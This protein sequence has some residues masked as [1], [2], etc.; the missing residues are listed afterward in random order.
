MTSVADQQLTPQAVTARSGSSFLAGFALL[1]GP[2]RA[3]MTAIYAFCRVAD[4]A[5]DDANS[6][7]EGEQRLAFWR[8]ELERAERGTPTT[9]IGVAL[10]QTFARFGSTVAPLRELLDGMAMD[11]HTVSYRTL[12]ALEVYCHRVASAVGLGCLPVLGANGADA[13][14]FAE[15]L[16]RAL[17]L[18]NILRDIKADAEMG[19]VYMPTQW[20]H[21]CRVDPLWLLGSGPTMAYVSGGPVAQ[22]CERI[23]LIARER[24][25]EADAALRRLPW[26]M[27]RRLLPARIMGVIYRDLLRLLALRGGNLSVG[28]LRVA[29]G[30]KFWLSM[31]VLLGVGG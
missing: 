9:P 4:D 25:A 2:R 12:D 11:L 5:V 14:H 31:C 21:E 7:S 8:A 22:V 16:G 23:A 19:R 3:G 6:A 18:T 13:E 20:L 10:Q 29:R 15:R 26:R 30:R 17:Q 28:R 27:R 24:F 1:F